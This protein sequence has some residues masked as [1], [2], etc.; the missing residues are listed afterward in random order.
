MVKLGTAEGCTLGLL[1]AVI[2]V[3][4]IWIEIHIFL[5]SLDNIVR[6]IKDPD[7]I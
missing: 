7:S 1:L 6:K 4:A 5:N 2:E 3:E